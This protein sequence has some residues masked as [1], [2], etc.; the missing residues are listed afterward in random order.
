MVLVLIFTLLLAFMT[1]GVACM[2]SILP[3]VT[4]VEKKYS[5]TKAVGLSLGV[6]TSFSIFIAIVAYSIDSMSLDMATL[7]WLTYVVLVSM[8]ATLIFPKISVYLESYISKISNLISPINKS[9]EV[10]FLSGYLSGI[11]LGLMWLPCAVPILLSVAVLAPIRSNDIE[12]LIVL[13]TYALVFGSILMIFTLKGNSLISKFGFVQKN[14]A[15]VQK[16]IGIF[17]ILIFT[18]LY[19]N[20]DRLLS[21]VL[22]SKVPGL[23]VLMD[24]ELRNKASVINTRV[25]IPSSNKD[26]NNNQSANS[27]SSSL[28]VYGIAPEVSGLSGVINGES[29]TDENTTGKNIM[30]VFWNYSCLDCNRLVP[31]LN[32]WNDKYRDNGLIILALHA[33]EFDF[34]RN[35][36]NLQKY[37]ED[38]GIRFPIAVDGNYETWKNFNN[39][40]SPATYLIDSNGYVRFYKFGR[41]APQETESAIQQLLSV[42][43]DLTNFNDFSGEEYRTSPQTHLGNARQTNLAEDQSLYI[44]RHD[45][46]H[47]GVLN[48]DKFSFSGTWDITEDSA[49]SANNSSLFI[50]FDGKKAYATLE[51]TNNADSISVYINDVLVSNTDAGKDVKNGKVELN[52][53]RL[54]E[55]VNLKEG[56]GGTLRIDITSGNVKIYSLSFL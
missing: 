3:I 23:S 11:S 41:S 17:L 44:G 46:A 51:P 26:V 40:Y 36:E 14:L 34:E 22:A 8:G 39:L 53:P 52:G 48:K 37:V 54:Y 55:L 30:I 49:I 38:M 32:S 25:V 13:A 7:R 10:G 42:S 6:I 56:N 5:R 1:L 33:P 15:I 31:Y 43:G 21:F 19:F 16:V 18:M 2:W 47:P 24:L 9:P 50:N 27:D 12:M 45:Y 4:S 20:F 28:P 29:L 35:E